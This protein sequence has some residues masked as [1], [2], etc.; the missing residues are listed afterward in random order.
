[1]KKEKKDLLKN[2]TILT[3]L[4]L[5]RKTGEISRIELAKNTSQ[6]PANITKITKK[7][8]DSDFIVEVGLS[9]STGGRPAKLL[10]LNE[11]IGNVITIYLAPDYIEL[12]LYSLNMEIIYKE[13]ID[14]WINTKDKILDTILKLIKRGIKTSQLEILGIGVAVNG[15]VD[16]TKG[17][18]LYSPHYKWFNVELKNFIE[19]SVGI[20]TYIEN[21]VRCMALGEKNYGI[22]KKVENFIFINIGNGVGSALYLN[23]ELYSGTNFGAGEIGHIPV[24]NYGRRCKCGKI[25]CLENYISNEVLEEKYFESTEI[26]I[27]AKEIYGN[28]MKADEH[29]NKLINETISYLVKGFTPLINLLNPSYII[30][31]GD[32]NYGK[33][34]IYKQ[35]KNELTKKTFGSLNDVLEIHNTSLGETAVHLGCATLI[36]SKLF[37]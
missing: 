8:I 31:N 37:K 7:L 15:L 2:K 18:S 1:M 23:N 17:I 13:K 27:K 6:T 33:E 3:I 16:S 9:D 12:I 35:I 24:E 32:I 14:I 10:K 30:L 29:I 28:F 36:L 11:K 34:Q 20:H 25:G 5:I 21:D 4:E 26:S 22:A 19:N